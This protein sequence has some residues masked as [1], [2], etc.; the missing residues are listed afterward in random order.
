MRPWE[1]SRRRS[2][3]QP[4]NDELRVD[5]CDEEQWNLPA[6]RFRLLEDALHIVVVGVRLRLEHQSRPQSSLEGYGQ[7]AP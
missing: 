3:T 6:S 7:R 1:G 2:S 5:E 4:A